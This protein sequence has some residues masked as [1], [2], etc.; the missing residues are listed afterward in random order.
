M[1]VV[2]GTVAIKP[3]GRDAA[4]QAALKVV[5]ATKLEPGCQTYDFWSDLADPNLFHVFEE[6]DSKAA[7]DAHFETAHMAE[8]LEALPAFVA[9][10]A[11]IKLYEIGSVSKLM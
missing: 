9:G 6:W 11:D 7:L 1:I 5:A 10:P 3:E 2:A 8:F 4:V